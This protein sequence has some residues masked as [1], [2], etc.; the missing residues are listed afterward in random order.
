MSLAFIRSCTAFLAAIA[1]SLFVGLPTPAMAL[2]GVQR[3]EIETVIRE[4]LLANPEILEEMQKSLESKKAAARMANQ[5]KTLS[6]MKDLIYNSANQVEIGEPDAPITIVEFYD[7]NCGFCARALADMTKLLETEKGIRFVLKEFPV[8]G[9]ASLE[10]HK[11]SLA[12]NKLLPAKSGD[13]HRALLIAPGR[14]DGAVAMALALEMGADETA[15]TAEI[16]KPAILDA[17]RE[18]YKLADGLG[19]TGTP[20]YIVGEEVVFGAVGFDELNKK[21]ANVRECGKSVC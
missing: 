17:V 12:F 14:K 16:A 11:V 21:V 18:V 5:A 19:I 8:L 2:D 9:E 3:G 20:S 13:F 1:I 4:Y 15:L 7:Y 10:A 6:E